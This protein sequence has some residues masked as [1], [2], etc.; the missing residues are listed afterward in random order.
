MNHGPLQAEVSSQIRQGLH[1]V[2]IEGRHYPDPRS[3]QPNP[4]RPCPY[5]KRFVLLHRGPIL[6]QKK[7]TPVEKDLGLAYKEMTKGF[8][9]IRTGELQSRLAL[10]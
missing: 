5:L 9:L 2:G 4:V 1:T 8:G 6:I 7:P 10:T 3:L